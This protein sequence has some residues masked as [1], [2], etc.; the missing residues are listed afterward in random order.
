[1]ARYPELCTVQY[2]FIAAHPWDLARRL[3]RTT[4]Y[5]YQVAH[6]ITLRYSRQF[7]SGNL[8]TFLFELN[9]NLSITT[10]YFNPFHLYPECYPIA[11]LSRLYLSILHPMVSGAKIQHLIPK[12]KMP[13]LA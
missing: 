13:F 12:G 8:R 9:K 7:Q 10:L 3:A 4:S 5:L 11:T 2:L 1:M 6:L